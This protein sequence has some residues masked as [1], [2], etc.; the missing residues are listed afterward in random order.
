MQSL[1]ETFRQDD[2]EMSTNDGL[3]MEVL[4][5][6]VQLKGSLAWYKCKEYRKHHYYIWKYFNLPNLYTRHT[7]KVQYLG[8]NIIKNIQQDTEIS[9]TEKLLKVIFLI[10]SYKIFK[11]PKV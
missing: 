8:A 2:M 1:R 4:M 11:Y 9:F 6:A 3:H 5:N 7:Y 10:S